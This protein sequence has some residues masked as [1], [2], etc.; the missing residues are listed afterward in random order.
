MAPL[1]DIDTISISFGGLLALDRASVE[2]EPGRVTGLIGPNGAGKT[3][4][5]NIITGLQQPT[6][7]RVRLDGV[8]VTRAKR[9]IRAR[10]G[11]A[12]TFQR[13]EPFGSLTA[14][15]N[16]LVALE[17]RRRWATE[18]YD[19]TALADE[20]LEQVGIGAVADRKVDSLP[21]GTARLVEL[22][23]ALGTAPR[24]L[25]LDEPSSGLD[26]DE[27]ETLG[28][29]LLDLAG[30]GLAILLVEHDMSFVMGTCAYINVLDF[31]RII[32][33][34]S[35]N[36]IQIDPEVQRAYLGTTAGKAS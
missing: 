35:P 32:A 2:V 1:L 36:E 22:A 10:L 7:G 14:R 31:G 18:R 24:V 13:L 34:G 9:H 29:L 5:F 6:S 33:R 25:L 27:T 19:A 30:R 21:T 8:D 28:R 23:R 16:V 12:R 17:M 11:I 3:T 4:L 26:G 20:L 15:E